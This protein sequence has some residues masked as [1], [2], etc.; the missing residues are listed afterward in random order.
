MQYHEPP[1]VGILWE[2]YLSQADIHN[3]SLQLTLAALLT[4][5]ADRDRV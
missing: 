1:A 3:Q 4:G 2:Y 5:P